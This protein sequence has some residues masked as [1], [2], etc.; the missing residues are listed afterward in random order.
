MRI[1]KDGRGIATARDF[2][3]HEGLDCPVHLRVEFAALV[4]HID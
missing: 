2:L 4:M 3:E 1:R